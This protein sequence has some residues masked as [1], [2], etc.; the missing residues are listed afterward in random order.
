MDK[1]VQM[2]SLLMNTFKDIFKVLRRLSGEAELQRVIGDLQ[3]A[4]QAYSLKLAAPGVI[5]VN[6]ELA[7]MKMLR[8]AISEG[9][10]ISEVISFTEEVLF[11]IQAKN[12][13][14]IIEKLEVPEFAEFVD[15]EYVS[16]MPPSVGSDNSDAG[17]SPGGTEGGDKPAQEM[18]VEGESSKEEDSSHDDNDGPPGNNGGSSSSDS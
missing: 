6:P 5:T 16:D 10:T 18:I 14:L 11:F 12:E 17:N 13:K 7:R 8:K 2:M 4:A 15:S 3:E 1:D 9:E